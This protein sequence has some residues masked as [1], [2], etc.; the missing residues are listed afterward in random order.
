MYVLGVNPITS[1]KWDGSKAPM[2]EES[3]RENSNAHAVNN[4]AAL[5]R[6]PTQTLHE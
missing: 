1:H 6:V 2:D 5:D 3:S 4:A